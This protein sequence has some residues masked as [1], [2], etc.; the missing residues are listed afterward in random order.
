MKYSG[1]TLAADVQKR[2]HAKKVGSITEGLMILSSWK[3]TNYCKYKPK[4]Y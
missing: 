4:A 3:P 2:K 1:S